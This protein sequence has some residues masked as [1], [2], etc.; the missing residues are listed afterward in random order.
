MNDENPWQLA[1]DC[2]RKDIPVVLLIV[3][4]S[5]GSTPGQ[6]GFKMAVAADGRL[7]GTIGGGIVEQRFIWKAREKLESGDSAPLLQRQVHDHGHDHGAQTDHSGMI[8]GGEQTVALYPCRRT[9]LAIIQRIIERL[10]DPSENRRIG[11]LRLSPSG[12]SFLP[13][14]RNSEDHGFRLE[15]EN[16]WLYQENIGPIHTAYI[17]GGGHVGQALARVLAML[18][19]HIVILDERA[20]LG[21]LNN[22]THADGKVLVSYGDIERHIPDGERNYAVIMTPNH[23][24][25]KQVLEQLLDKKLRYLGMMGSARK[26]DE[27]FGQLQDEGIPPEKLSGIHAPIGLPIKSHTP[28]EIAI[29]IAAEMISVSRLSNSEIGRNARNAGYREAV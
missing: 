24:A 20:D 15:A 1:G 2:L 26:V 21:T 9:D 27:I 29:S 19:F 14:E 8:C 10:M 13:D 22:N 4:E 3:V 16:R 23:K 25:D 28:A 6:A 18:D 11:I 17:I 7:A 5:H 12:L